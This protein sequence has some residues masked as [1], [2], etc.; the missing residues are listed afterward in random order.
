[1]KNLPIG[2]F[3]SGLGGLTVVKAL[4]DLLPN[5]SII[6]YGDLAHLPYG[7]KGQATVR[8]LSLDCAHFLYKKGIKLLVV[9]CNT[10]SSIALKDIQSAFD[11]PVIGV[12]EP[13]SEEAI[14]T[15]KNKR[16]GVIG[17]T[18]TIVSNSYYNTIN[19]L[20]PECRVFQSA[21]PLLVPLIE[22][23]WSS[24]PAFYLILNDYLK[25][26][27]DKEIDTI[28]LGC[29]HYPL[30][31]EAIQTM[32]PSFRVIDSAE[33]TANKVKQV[34]EGKSAL[35]SSQR[36]EHQ[37]FASDISE[38]FIDLSKKVMGHS[39]DIKLV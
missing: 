39:I 30:I 37:F 1:M 34:L 4:N 33:S 29:T 14:N 8:K 7:S 23:G 19:E 38:T 35:H 13:G 32:R 36:A 24:H 27:D 25:F 31:K 21:T 15:S 20:A 16:I 12:V 28:V 9:A 18:R 26:F 10:A 6:Y 11:I 3:D 17:T 5:E 2:V 22:E